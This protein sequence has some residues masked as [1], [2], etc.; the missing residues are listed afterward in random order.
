M[1][2]ELSKRIKSFGWR[3]LCVSLVAGLSW[4]SENLGLLEVPIWAQGIVGLALGEITKW[5]NN[6]TEL[7]GIKLK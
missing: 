3:F 2:N 4:G 6:N 7:F 5:L 1:N